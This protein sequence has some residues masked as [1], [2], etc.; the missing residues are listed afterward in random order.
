VSVEISADLERRISEEARR[1]SR[2]VAELVEEVLSHY[3][4]GPDAE[5][6]GIDRATRPRLP[7]VWAAENF[8]DWRPPE[9]PIKPGRRENSVPVK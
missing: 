3:L 2:T 6:L 1:R 5:T 9:G 8:S 4:D 7:D